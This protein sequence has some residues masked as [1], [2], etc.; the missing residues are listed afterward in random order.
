MDDKLPGLQ[1]ARA[2]AALTVAY[3]HSY[4]ALRIFTRDVHTGPF[5]KEWGF[6]VLTFFA[7][8]GSVSA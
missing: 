3:F 4:I 2:I 8:S 7:I 5:F 1:A 6:W